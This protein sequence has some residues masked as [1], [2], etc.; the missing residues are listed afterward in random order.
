MTVRFLFTLICSVS[1][2]VAHAQDAETETESRTYRSDIGINSIGLIN[3]LFDSDDDSFVTP[4]LFSYNLDLGKI[5]FRAAIGPKFNRSEVVRE[6]FTDSQEKVQTNIDYRVG[7]GWDIIEEKKWLVRTGFD[8]AGGYDLDKTIDDTGFD[9]VT[10]QMRE[11]SIG[12]GPFAQVIFRINDRISL[13]TDAAVYFTHFDSQEKE[14]FENF[15]EFD[16]ELSNTTGQRLDV[17]LPTSLFIH[18]HF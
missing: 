3:A 17:F 18:F 16:N 1:L 5:N 10:M 8:I 4:Y 15:P 6:G 9:K 12:G 2:S 13:S 7:L 14:I 11:W